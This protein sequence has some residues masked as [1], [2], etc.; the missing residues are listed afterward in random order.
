M[1]HGEFTVW[2]TFPDET[3]TAECRFVDAETA[4]NVAYRRSRSPA[5]SIGAITQIRITD[6]LDY[7]VFLW[8]QGEGVTFP[9]RSST[10][11][12]YVH[13]DDPDAVPRGEY[14]REQAGGGQR[15]K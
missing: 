4:V 8:E 13:E 14:A 11:G 1:D 12:H 3:V 15:S 5:A 2:L 9:P 7:T 10:T 6:G